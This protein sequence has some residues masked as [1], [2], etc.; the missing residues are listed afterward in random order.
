MLMTLLVPLLAAP[1]G[2]QFGEPV[3]LR[4]GDDFVKVEAP[5]YACPAWHDVDND[6]KKDL[7]VGQFKDGKIAIHKNLGGGKLA[8]R[9]WLMAEGEIAEVPGV[10]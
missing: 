4:G 5:G 9:Q 7:L 8:A 1:Q 6:G 10:W 2:P 3:R